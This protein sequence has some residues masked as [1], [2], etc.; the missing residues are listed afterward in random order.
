MKF[1]TFNTEKTDA[2]KQ[3]MFFGDPVNVARYDKQKYEF[4]EKQIKKQ[5]SFFWVPEE[6]S[7]DRDPANF[8]KELG[9]A[10]QHIFTSNLYYQILLDSVQGR[11]PN[12]AL[13]PYCSL[14]ELETLIETWSFFETIHSRSYTH[15]IRGIYNDPSKMLDGIMSIEPV[16]ERAK[17]VTQ[18]YDDFIEYANWYN[19]L[20]IGTHKVAGKTIK[21]DEYELR[22][23]LYLMIVAINILEGIRFYV[24][25]ACT[26][27]F[28]ESMHVMEKSAKIIKMICRDE[29]LHLAITS[30]I[31][32]K[33][34]DGSEGKMMADIAKECEPKV[35]EMYAEAVEQEEAWAE[36]LFSKGSIVGLNA[37]ILKE[38]VQFIANKRMRTLGLKGPYNV[39]SNPLPWTEHWINSKAT[40]VAP[41]EEEITSYLIGGINNDIGDDTF[42]GLKL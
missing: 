24:S 1:Q 8:H 19:M 39:P 22:K 30:H 31:L 33:F 4:F 11:A 14:P 6:I 41:Q 2:T 37:E 42:A 36:Y 34:A 25:F 26:W 5:L 21:V 28:A 7:L 20:G 16:I 40:Q 27:A 17:A 23:K 38:Y 12:V 32:K 15:I 9:E 29:N 3:P 13:L 18:Y 10:G 35:Y